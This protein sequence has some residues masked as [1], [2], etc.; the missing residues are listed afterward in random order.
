[1]RFQLKI[2]AV[3]DVTQLYVDW[4]KDKNVTRY[5]NNQYRTFTLEKT[6]RIC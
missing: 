5:S 2:L 6:K 1:M 4:Y 3:S